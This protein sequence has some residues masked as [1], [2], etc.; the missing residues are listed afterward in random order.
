MMRAI[1]LSDVTTDDVLF[2][3]KNKTV[4]LTWRVSKTDSQGATISRTLQCVCE[5][6]CDL[7]CPYS[8]LRVL[9]NFAKLKNTPEKAI[10]TNTKD[11]RATKAEI[12]KSWQRL[13]GKEVRGHSTRRSGALQYIRKGWTVS[14]VIYLGR[15]KSSIILEYAQEAFQ[16]MPVNNSNSFK[17][18]TEKDKQTSVIKEVVTQKSM[19]EDDKEKR[20]LLTRLK[21]RAQIT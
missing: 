15:W 14:Q 3:E 4:T 7:R 11:L 20:E 9:V 2:I 5:D 21:G 13:Y 18:E 8:A 10:A 19:P 17:G 16:S 1:E 12:V 6:Q